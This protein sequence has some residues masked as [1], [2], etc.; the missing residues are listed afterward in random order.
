VHEPTVNE[1]LLDRF[2]GEPVPVWRIYEPAETFAVLGAGGLP[3][4]DLILDNLRDRGVPWRRRM[5]GG[6]AV[7][8]SAGQVVLALVKE[9]D[10][11]FKNREYA[12]RINEWII[13]TLS[14]LGILH[15]EARG[16]SDLAICG[17]KILGTSIYRRRR[18]LFYQASL[19]VSN[20]LSL[21][22]SFLSPPVH[23]PDYREGRSHMEFC[24]TLAREGYGASVADV[25]TGLE[26]AVRRGIDGL[27]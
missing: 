27:K 21:F 12:S 23:E 13:Q 6:G 3:E 4:R 14:A 1:D 7:V 5:G 11:P 17:R 18:I 22:E 2:L 16:I 26:T 10:S 9:V 8:L 19:L 24:T 20:D 15:I 25:V